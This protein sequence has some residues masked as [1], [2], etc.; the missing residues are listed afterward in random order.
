MLATG[1]AGSIQC[2]VTSPP[3]FGQRD[4]KHAE[5]IGREST[6]AAY[7]TELVG[8]FRAVRRVLKDDGTLWLNL[9]DTMR[10]K[11]L[12]MMPARVALALQA[13]GW[14]LRSSIVWHKPNP[15]PESCND[16]PTSAYEFVYLLTKKPNYYYDADAIAEASITGDN[17]RPYTSQGAKALDGRDVWHSGRPR[18]NPDATKRNARNVWT[19][20]PKPFRGAH[21]ATMPP[22]LVE[23]CILAGSRP[24][25]TVLDPFAGAGTT[26]LVAARLGR[27]SV[28]IELNPEYVEMA[29]KRLGLA[30][31]G[32]AA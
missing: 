26:A 7:V 1:P 13:D 24:G 31:K 15:M 21:F 19:I 22:D 4:Y 29:R 32:M 2:C 9:G 25:Q 30:S 28:G 14:Y 6:P 5:Q 18:D 10:A 12:Q 20:P 27:H 8:V 3:Y 11:Q 23:R 17:R 16:R